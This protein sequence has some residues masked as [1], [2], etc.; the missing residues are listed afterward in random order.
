MRVSHCKYCACGDQGCTLAC[1][2]HVNPF[3]FDVIHVNTLKCYLSYVVG[4]H[5]QTLRGSISALSTP[6][7]QVNSNY[8]LESS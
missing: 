1:G 3:F 4:N 6:I 2:L 7:L 5:V 8:S